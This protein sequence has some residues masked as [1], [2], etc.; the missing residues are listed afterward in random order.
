MK[1]TFQEHFVNDIIPIMIK[2]CD[3]PVPRVVSHAL[4]AITNLVECKIKS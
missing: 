1:P 3:D 4:A 2:V